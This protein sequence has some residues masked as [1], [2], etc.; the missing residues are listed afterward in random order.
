MLGIVASIILTFGNMGIIV[1][2]LFVT[3]WGV[4]AGFGAL[5]FYDL[6]SAEIVHTKYRAGAQGLLF[7][8]ARVGVGII[9]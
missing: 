9:S 6:W 1:L 4:A 5:A 8:I 2:M 3:L 7:F